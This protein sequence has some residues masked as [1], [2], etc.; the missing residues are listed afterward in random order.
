MNLEW[1]ILNACIEWDPKVVMFHAVAPK[2]S[3]QWHRDQWCIFLLS[4]NMCFVFIS[5]KLAFIF[6]MDWQVWSCVYNMSWSCWNSLA[7][8][9][10]KKGWMMFMGW[11]SWFNL[12]QRPIGVSTLSSWGE[13][14][15]SLKKTLWVIRKKK[16]LYR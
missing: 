9:M 8:F 16:L 6:D 5:P 2:K 10:V 4:F 1:V 14:C 12:F 3:Q 15:P 13:W 7:I 11:T